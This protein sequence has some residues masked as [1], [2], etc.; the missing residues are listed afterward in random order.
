MKYG[1]A[2]FV[3]FGNFRKVSTTYM[4]LDIRNIKLGDDGHSSLNFDLSPKMTQVSTSVKLKLSL[5][6]LK[7]GEGI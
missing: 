1:Y 6:M 7:P 2:I 3:N 4:F 5:M